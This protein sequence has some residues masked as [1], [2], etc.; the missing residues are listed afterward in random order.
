MNPDLLAVVISD[1]W[2]YTLLCKFQKGF[3]DA[4]CFNRTEYNRN[5]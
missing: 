5:I 1:V 4:S 2:D 3:E